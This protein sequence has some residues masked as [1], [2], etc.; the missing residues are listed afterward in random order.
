MYPAYSKVNGTQLVGIGRL[1]GDGA[2]DVMVRNGNA[3]TAWAGNGPG[4]LTGALP[5]S[6]D[7]TEYDWI[8]GVGDVGLTGSP[9]LVVRKAGK[10]KLCCSRAAR[11]G[12]HAP[13]DPGAGDEGLRPGRL[14]HERGDA[15]GLREAV[16]PVGPAPPVR[17]GPTTRTTEPRRASGSVKVASS[18]GEAGFAATK[19]RP[20]SVR[21]LPAAAALHSSRWVVPAAT[22]RRRRR[23]AGRTPR[24]RPAATTPRSRRRAPRQAAGRRT[25]RPSAAASTPAPA[26]RRRATPSAPA[27]PDRSPPRPA[28]S[29]SRVTTSPAVHA[30]PRNT[31]VSQCSGRST[32]ST[33]PRSRSCSS[34]RSDA[35]F[36]TQLAYV[37]TDS[38]TRS[39]VVSSYQVTSGRPASRRRSASRISA[40]VVTAATVG[41]AR[42]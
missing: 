30:A 22:R 39:P 28:R 19:R 15:F 18:G 6:V 34:T 33:S 37:A 23:S 40:N 16:E 35:V 41:C 17:P 10:G 12:S 25:G 24:T 5:V 7:V 26:G 3:L 14:G 21:R 42:D 20:P 11:P 1:D 9:D 4:G 38:S 29:S 27:R 13:R 31:A 36:A 2:P 8:V 32:R